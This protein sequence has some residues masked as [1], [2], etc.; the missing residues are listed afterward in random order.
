MQDILAK[1]G[2]LASAIKKSSPYKA[3]MDAQQQLDGNEPVRKLM[4]DFDEYSRKIR[5]KEKALQP[6]EVEEKRK[7]QQLREQMQSNALV[8][9]LLRAQADYAQLMAKVNET[10]EATLQPE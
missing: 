9:A 4:A 5:E 3:L 8:Q 10:I 7:V 2:E 1:A 6:V